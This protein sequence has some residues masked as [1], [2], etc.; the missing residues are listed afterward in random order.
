[1]SPDNIIIAR[2]DWPTILSV[3]LLVVN[4]RGSVQR[5]TYGDI[6][7]TVF[8]FPQPEDPAHFARI[9]IIEGSAPSY[10][11]SGTP[12]ILS[13]K[14][15]SQMIWIDLLLLSDRTIRVRP[16]PASR[17]RLGIPAA[18]LLRCLS[19][20]LSSSLFVPD[21]GGV[22]VRRQ[23]NLCISWP[24]WGDEVRW[25]PRDPSLMMPDVGY[26]RFCST[27]WAVQEMRTPAQLK[28]Q[29]SPVP[30]HTGT[31]DVI[32]LYDFPHPIQMQRESRL[33]P[34]PFDSSGPL[35]LIEVNYYN[36]EAVLPKDITW[37]VPVI[38]APYRQTIFI[39]EIVRPFYMI[40]P[41]GLVLRNIGKP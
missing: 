16:T 25:V 38:S 7:G 5:G 15:D 13:H 10:C 40:S 18:H 23:N 28:R 36:R 6:K 22:E 31:L 32:A 21:L 30:G 29:P 24:D 4:I 11:S 12:T 41:D 3:D 14:P 17:Y 8:S 39:T 2:Y 34:P 1:M 35:T 20:A 27:S 19:K 26:A 33:P 9:D 37:N